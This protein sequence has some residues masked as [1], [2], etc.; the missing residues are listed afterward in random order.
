LWAA[1]GSWPPEKRADCR[2]EALLLENEVNLKWGCA[3][4]EVGQTADRIRFLRERYGEAAYSMLMNIKKAIDPNG[5][6]N[7]GNLEGTGYEL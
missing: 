5:I 2:R 3:S 7:P 1:P 4:G 6:L